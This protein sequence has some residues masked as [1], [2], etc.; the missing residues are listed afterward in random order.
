MCIVLS[1][2]KVYLRIRMRSISTNEICK[3]IR[4]PCVGKIFGFYAQFLFNGLDTRIRYL[5]SIGYAW[6]NYRGKCTA[7]KI[8]PTFPSEMA[9]R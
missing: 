4:V 5:L 1:L 6:V 9:E 8:F 2:F 7:Q 3:Q